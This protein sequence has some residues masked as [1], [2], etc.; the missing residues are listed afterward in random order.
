MQF[1]PEILKM[2]RLDL[3][4]EAGH[5]VIRSA[6]GRDDAAEYSFGIEEEYFLA[7]SI[8]FDVA[9]Q[10]PNDLFEAANWSTGGQAM[11]EMLQGQLEVASNAHV[12]AGDAREELKFLRREV[13]AVAAQYGL[14]IMASGT[15]PTASWRVSRPSPKPRYEEMIEDPRTIGP[16]NLLCGMHVHV[17]LPDPEKR[18]AVMRAMIPY[19]PLFVALSTSSPFWNSKPTGLKGYRLA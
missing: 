9:M 3:D 11:R 18:F 14:A 4:R 17:Q 19:I 7:N 12:D 1:N 2:L 16:R 8:N 13:A 5:L 10:T 15:H 6:T